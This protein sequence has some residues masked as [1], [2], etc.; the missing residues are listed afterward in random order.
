MN[1]WLGVLAIIV[2]GL[3]LTPVFR[4]RARRAD[5][6]ERPALERANRLTAYGYAAALA[7]TLVWAIAGS[8]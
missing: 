5:E 3:V 6:S 7:F 4:W 1:R 2:M 8:F